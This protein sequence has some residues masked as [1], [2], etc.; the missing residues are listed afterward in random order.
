MKRYITFG[1]G[2]FD[3]NK[4]KKPAN[5]RLGNKPFGGLWCSPVDS[6]CGWKDWC[7][8]NEF[9]KEEGGLDSHFTF[10]LKPEARI[11]ELNY[12]DDLEDLPLLENP[13]DYFSI[14]FEKLLEEYDAL[15]LTDTGLSQLAMLNMHTCGHFELPPFYGWDCESTLILNPHVILIDV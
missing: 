12:T 1:L 6:D 4:F 10:T 15:E 7:I 8:A 13:Y 3:I 5:L 11:K 14:D 2:E 9:L